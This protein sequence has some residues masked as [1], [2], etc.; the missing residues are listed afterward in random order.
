MGAG[1]PA[2]DVPAVV[3]GNDVVLLE[4]TFA[5]SPGAPVPAVKIRRSVWIA[6]TPDE[7]GQIPRILGGTQ[8]FVVAAPGPF[9]GLAG[10]SA[11][12]P[13]GLNR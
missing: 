5:F 6:G 10:V 1:D 11:G 9:G 13:R 2:I 4:G 3:D 7:Q 12:A 8:P